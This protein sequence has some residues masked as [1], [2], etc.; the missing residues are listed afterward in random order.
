MD[1]QIHPSSIHPCT[2]PS[3]LQR[4][5]YID[6]EPDIALGSGGAG[7]GKIK[8]WS[9]AS[10]SLRLKRKRYLSPICHATKISSHKLRILI[11]VLS[12]KERPHVSR[13]YNKECVLGWAEEGSGLSG[14]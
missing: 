5:L 11:Q 1:Q 3:I 7:E 12:G 8:T 6:Y 4:L 14:I 13:A 2:H 9:L 10:L